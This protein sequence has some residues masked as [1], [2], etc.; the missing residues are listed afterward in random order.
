MPSP[1]RYASPSPSV[2]ASADN[3][4]LS[5]SGWRTIRPRPA[6]SARRVPS[7][8]RLPLAR[9]SSSPATF[10]QAT[11]STV[12]TAPPSTTIG[13][14]RSLRRSCSP[15]APGSSSARGGSQ[16][17]G[18]GAVRM[19]SATSRSVSS[20][21]GS[22]LTPGRRRPITSKPQRR[23]AWRTLGAASTIGCIT[24]GRL[25]SGHQEGSTPQAPR[26]STPTITTG[27]PFTSSVWPSTDRS[28]PNSR[29][30]KP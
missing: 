8:R 17:S 30:Q 10:A 27:V 9:A 16:A 18:G 5:V 23:G 24:I 1:T 14:R 15:C 25:R 20:R 12:A 6:P 19:A 11:S 7:S 2:P 22:S 13:S 26:G 28:P 29:C 3:S 4:R 21:A